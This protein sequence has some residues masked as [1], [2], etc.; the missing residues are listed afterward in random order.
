MRLIIL[1]LLTTLFTTL[2]ADDT[3]PTQYTTV[4]TGIVCQSCKTTVIESLKKLPGVKEVD[5][6]KGE[7]EGT[8]KLSFTAR[9][10]S[11]TK[12]DAERALGEHT[13]EFS[14]VSFEKK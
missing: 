5:F 4:V 13:K 2:R 11:L 14:I 7:K 1:A 10:N 8:H 3:K 12:N 6:A 9:S